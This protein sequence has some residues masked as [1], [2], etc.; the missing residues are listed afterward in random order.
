MKSVL[1]SLLGVTG[2]AMALLAWRNSETTFECAPPDG[3]GLSAGLHLAERKLA[4]QGSITWRMA[5]KNGNNQERKIIVANDLDPR[6][7]CRLLVT[8]LDGR[9]AR[10]FEPAAR[11]PATTG[12]IN[13]VVTIPAGKWVALDPEKAP[14]GPLMGAGKYNL[15]AV[16]GGG[17][18]T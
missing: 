3:K 13:R 9:P 8:P 6:A 2:A 5:L 17:G 1:A 11:G 16:Y 4:P 15:T 18:F 12:N 10:E 14:L 7:R